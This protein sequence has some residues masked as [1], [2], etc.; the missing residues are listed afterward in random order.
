MLD[1][2]LANIWLT[3]EGLPQWIC[4]TL[5]GIS[6]SV[7]IVV[8]TVGWHCWHPYTTN[9]KKV[10]VHVSSDGSKFKLWDTFTSQQSRGTQ[11]FCCAPI[12]SSV[13]PF[14]ALEITETFGGNQTYMNRV[15][16]YSEEIPSP[17][18]LLK[19]VGSRQPPNEEEMY[20]ELVSFNS[21]T[22]PGSSTSAADMHND[23]E[24]HDVRNTLDG[25]SRSL[26]PSTVNS[27]AG[28][29]DVLQVIPTG[30]PPPR[31]TA[32]TAPEPTDSGKIQ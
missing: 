23:N 20:S 8:R 21:S 1:P 27:M 15:Y 24:F 19:T 30:S 7:D 16:L 18:S 32:T 17:P 9:P 10:T 5:G 2:L 12:S 3:E 4:I 22:D 14:I 13:H 11:L 26:F 29:L 25:F 31:Y 28:E 6:Q